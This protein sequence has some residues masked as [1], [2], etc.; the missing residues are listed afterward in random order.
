MPVPLLTVLD[1]HA[2]VCVL[3]LFPDR[4]ASMTVPMLSPIGG[5]DTSATYLANR[6]GGTSWSSSTPRVGGGV[7]PLSAATFRPSRQ[8]RLIFARA[9]PL[10]WAADE[11]LSLSASISHSG[12]PSFRCNPLRSHASRHDCRFRREPPLPLARIPLNLACG[13]SLPPLGALQTISG[14]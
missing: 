8:L 3:D 1:L 2:Q 10:R 5:A 11:A 7:G 14:R 4:T 12:P 6:A 13:D 9:P